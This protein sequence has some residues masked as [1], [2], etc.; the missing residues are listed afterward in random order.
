[1]PDFELGTALNTFIRV[2]GPV[3][4]ATIVWRTWRSS[5]RTTSKFALAGFLVITVAAIWGSLWAYTV[6]NGV[7][8]GL[9]AR[10]FGVVQ[11]STSGLLEALGLVLIVYAFWLELRPSMSVAA[12]E[13]EEVKP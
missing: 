1:M 12:P 5:S 11:A 4:A 9:N 13:R 2:A 8:S 3:F 10:D 6:N 7:A